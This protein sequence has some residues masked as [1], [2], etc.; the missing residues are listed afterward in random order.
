MLIT[1][2]MISLNKIR[3]LL[4]IILFMGAIIISHPVT[5]HAATVTSYPIPSCYTTS[6]QYTVKADSTNIP[7][8]DTSAVFINYNYCNFSF[9][10]TTTIT[11][12]ASE[13]INT[14]NISP[15]ALGITA[16]KSGNTLTFT[17]S[18]SRYLIVKINGLKDLV[19]AADADETSVPASSGT[20]I[21]N[22]KTQYGADS[23]GA[24]MATTAIQNAI[25]AAN[26]QGGGIVYVP[27]GVYTCGNLILKSNVSI[28]LEGGSVI[29]CSGNP[30][31]YTTNFHKNS[32]NKDGTWFISTE[33][34]ANNVKIYGRGTIDGNGHY[35]RNTKSY[36]NNILV[37]L[38]CSNFTVDGITIRDSGLWATTVVRSN[39][40]TIQNTKHFNNN[41]HDYEDDAIDIEESQ[42]VSIKHTIAVSE[43]DTYSF[44]TWDVETTDI[45]ANWPG[46]SENLS[47]VVVDDCFAWSRC[48]A[49][50]VGDGVKQ[51]QDG[52]VVKNSW[53][54]RCWR[55]MAVG[56]LYGTTAAQNIIFDNIDVEGFWPRSG[57]H[58]RWFDLSAKTGPIKNVVYN[59]INL[60]A[61][62][63]ISIMKGWSDTATVTGTTLNNIRYNGV[64][65]T[66]LEELNITDTNSYAAAPS[67]NT[68][69]FEAEGYNIGSGVSYESCTD[70]GIDVGG[71]S[72]GDYIAFKNVDFGSAAI[73]SINVKVATANSGGTVEFHLDSPTGTLLGSWTAASTGGWQNWSTV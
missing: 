73:T 49:F 15:L 32:L 4:L 42:N 38:Q 10:G 60:R 59:N 64:V 40:V 7:V 25:N 3:S 11:I 34:N 24:T 5:S 12:T 65:A 50:K 53:V 48:G 17:L 8:I 55:A 61:L 21:Y 26:I 63:E 72:N 2:K 16:T 52:I 58:S 27:A 22:I 6:P 19:I 43:D 36:L 57:V 56:H 39:N 18:E 69:K 68:L 71:G 54:Y 13:T 46:S 51:L 45:A 66:S 62:G 35:M 30:N 33:T 31:D 14:Y 67:W 1:N 23:T 28:Y 20:G 70:G 47:N 37:P 9:S 41:D 29:R 44:K